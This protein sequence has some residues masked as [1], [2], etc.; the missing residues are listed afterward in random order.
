MVLA[1]LEEDA[2]ARTDDL[3]WPAFPLTE[4][5]ALRD[6]DR[7]TVRVHMPSGAGAGRE[8]D[9][10]CTERGEI[11]RHGEPVDEDRPREPVRGTRIA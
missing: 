5:N 3:D 1:G 10:G 2:V 11:R 9:A 8:V 7:L 6:P 4:S